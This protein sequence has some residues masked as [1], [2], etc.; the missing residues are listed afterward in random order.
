VIERREP[1]PRTQI[2]GVQV[3]G[4]LER[5]KNRLTSIEQQSELIDLDLR[6]M[7]RKAL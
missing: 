5:M 3:L 4:K 1:E 6:E 7:E 2:I